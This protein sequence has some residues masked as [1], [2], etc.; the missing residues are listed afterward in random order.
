M[1]TTKQLHKLTE[2][3]NY[4]WILLVYYNTIQ[5]YK[6]FLLMFLFLYKACNHRT[7]TLVNEWLLP[8]HSAVRKNLTN[9]KVMHRVK[10]YFHLLY[11][12]LMPDSM[13]SFQ[14]VKFR[15]AAIWTRCHLPQAVN[16][17]K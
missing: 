1:I 9:N 13:L 2:T 8:R 5:I 7:N 15:H 16:I 10:N 11:I 14:L 17:K 4:T 6:I 12:N 3:E